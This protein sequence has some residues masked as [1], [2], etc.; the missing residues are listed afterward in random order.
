MLRTCSKENFTKKF[1]FMIISNILANFKN[2][3]STRGK[4]IRKKKTAKT[5]D[6]CGNL[7]TK[8]LS[9]P[10]LK[11]STTFDAKVVQKTASF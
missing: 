5:K 10:I 6:K 11:Q 7:D 9:F 1:I 8:Q 4:A 3:K 2:Y